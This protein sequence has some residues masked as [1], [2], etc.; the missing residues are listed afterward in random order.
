LTEKHL[1]FR[2][3][4]FLDT[5]VEPDK[6]YVLDIFNRR[7]FMASYMDMSNSEE[8]LAKLRFHLTAISVQNSLCPFLYRVMNE[9]SQIVFVEELGRGTLTQYAEYRQ[10]IA[11]NFTVEEMTTYF[12][13]LYALVKELWAY[14][15]TISHLNPSDILIDYTW[16]LRIRPECIIN[17]TVYQTQRHM[18]A[19]C[20][21]KLTEYMDLDV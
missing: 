1:L 16:K 20:L 17:S 21:S 15:L 4:I 19:S 14:S 11:K 2:P 12:H 7:I 3:F 8:I 18:I 13:Q 9:N 6:K 10:K 5:G